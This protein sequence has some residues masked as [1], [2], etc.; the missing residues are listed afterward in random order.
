MLYSRQTGK[1]KGAIERRFGFREAD[2][3]IVSEIVKA[4]LLGLAI[5]ASTAQDAAKEPN[6]QATHAD[7]EAAGTLLEACSCGVPCPCNFGQAPTGGFCHTV[8]AYRL[9]SAR[10]EGVAL[11]GLV[12]GGGE[13]GHGAAGFLDSRAT[14]A[15][16]PALEKLALAVFGQGGA[17]GGPRHFETVP[18]VA[19]DDSRKFRVRFGD[20]GGFEADILF[21]RDR[22]RPIVVENNTTWP[23]DRFVKGKTTQ[24][25]YQDPLG[26]RLRLD[27]VNANLGEF[28]LSSG[29]SVP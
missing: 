3:M 18:I 1:L 4:A 8:Y 2:E 9:K 11:D 15:Q 19:T 13:A 24:F 17:S 26:N 28:H 20:R 22:K 21:G 12:F 23:V 7:W 10:Y 14:A 29:R 5:L 27:G 6:K 25:V 16:R